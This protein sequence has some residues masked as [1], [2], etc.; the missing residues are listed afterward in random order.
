MLDGVLFFPVT[1][2]TAAGEVDVDLLA[3][4]VAKGVAAGP[5]GVFIGCGTGEFHAL[6]PEE[7]RTVVRTAVEA[8]GGRVPVYA[9]A[10]GSV[11]SAKAFAR[12]AAES[13]ADGLLLLPPY[14]VE[15]PQAGLVAYTR[16]V[17]AAT[18]LP[19]VVYNRNNARYNEASALEVAKLPNVV[20]FKDGTGDLDQVS[21][22]VRAV[23]D[24][25]EPLGKPFQF[26]NGLPTAEV[27]Q[28]AYRA[29][30]VTL[31]SSATFAFAPDVAL[32]F[33]QAL[34]T[35]N[36]PL[37]AALLREFYHPLVRL[38]DTVPGY[39]VS[40]IKAGVTMEG[41]P[42]G[43]VRAPL[44]DASAEDVAELQRIL[45]AGRA[46]LADALVH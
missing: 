4:H 5:G 2:L 24:A 39:A 20:G 41:I 27:S 44:V 10:G 42:A 21:R 16:E 46:V 13:G 31:Y 23:T 17:S 8:V 30:G 7:M 35:G 32:A 40:L 45:A 43:P 29:I 14:L 28:Q 15:M 38:R 19:V 12:V 3:Q 18:E 9:G 33:Y 25:L 37:V 1:P 26:F 11:A 34:E 6:D 22:I 36:E